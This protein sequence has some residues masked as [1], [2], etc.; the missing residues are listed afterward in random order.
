MNLRRSLAAALGAL[1]LALP[2]ATAVAQ[3][4]DAG[5]EARLRPLREAVETLVRR[6]EQGPQPRSPSPHA[7]VNRLAAASD[8]DLE[9]VLAEAWEHAGPTRAFGGPRFF[10]VRWVIRMLHDHVQDGPPVGPGALPVADPHGV[11]QIEYRE[12]W[13]STCGT[14]NEDPVV[15]TLE[16]LTLG[17]SRRRVVDP[18]A[19]RLL[20]ALVAECAEA[21][22]LLQVP[23]LDDLAR[24][25][26]EACAGD[27]A[28]LARLL[29]LARGPDAPAA[30]LTA[31]AWS[32][33]DEAE[34]ILWSAMAAAETTGDARRAA[35]LRMTEIAGGLMW[36]GPE[37]FVAGLAQLPNDVQDAVL[38][39]V[40]LD[41]AATILI[42]RIDSAESPERRAL[43]LDRLSSVFTDGG[44]D[45]R[46]I[47]GGLPMFSEAPACSGETLAQ[48]LGAV[49]AHAEADDQTVAQA[50]QRAAAVIVMGRTPVH[51]GPVSTGPSQATR[52][53]APELRIDVTPALRTLSR[54]CADGTARVHG[55]DP[56]VFG[57]D[58]EAGPSIGAYVTGTVPRPRGGTRGVTFASPE[59]RTLARVL[60]AA[61]SS[62]PPYTPPSL[63]LT[64]D[65]TPTR[66][67]LR[68]KNVGSVSA[69]LFP[70]QLGLADFETVT[71]D[72]R[73]S[74]NQPNE[75]DTPRASAPLPK[76]SLVVR[77]GA[78]PRRI[79]MAIEDAIVVAPQQTYEWDL[80]WTVDPDAFDHVAAGLVESVDV[81]GDRGVPVVTTFNAVWLR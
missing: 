18:P 25:T 9:R 72:D 40:G 49:A 34:S 79:S 67:A 43:E 26:G 5:R 35:P 6:V 39:A 56:P 28:T 60:G 80:P 20:D 21:P 74:G 32:G 59:R 45:D 77:L 14:C 52:Q 78:F 64:A 33:A 7:L 3:D 17:L 71:G 13:G 10:S 81:V 38:A 22:G 24:A 66:L 73:A 2:T 19:A 61:A 4:D 69:L 11:V 55:V 54:A 48:L 68:I 46:L 42:D 23:A 70:T 53:H 63:R 16:H 51:R 37:T 57:T 27:P 12:G 47:R 62:D 41:A 75:T 1:F 44:R 15:P 65:V 30:V 76:P 29:T 36:L 31:A 58:E 50:A 8:A